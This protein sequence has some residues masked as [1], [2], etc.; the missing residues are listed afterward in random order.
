[1]TERTAGEREAVAKILWEHNATPEQGRQGWEHRPNDSREHYLELADD[2]LDT[3]RALREAPISGQAA[4]TFPREVVE[5]YRQQ[6]AD[7]REE[8]AKLREAPVSGEP[9]GYVCNDCGQPWTDEHVC[10]WGC[11]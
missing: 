1:M 5:Q 7:A 6:L 2:V 11:P 4:Q 8:I 9:L 3:L 10:R